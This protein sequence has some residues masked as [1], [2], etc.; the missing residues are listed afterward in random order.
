MVIV[1]QDFLLGAYMSVSPEPSSEKQQP[2]LIKGILAR[3]GQILFMF[4]VLGLILF[5]G[6]GD[7]H[8]RAAWI[9]LGI[10]ILSVL[11]NS[12]FMLR[13][14]PETVAERGTAKGW[15]DWDKLI[16]GLWAAAQYLF[17]P[18]I[19]ALDHRFGWTGEISIHWQ[20]SGALVYALSLALSGWAMI[21][22]AYFSTAA[23][24]Q[25]DRGQK[26]CKSGPYRYVRHPGYIGFGLQSVST[27][28]LLGSA[29]ALIPAVLAVAL[30]VTRTVFE[31]HM[32]RAELSG[33][34]EYTHEVRF[35]L[36]PGI[37]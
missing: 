2:N 18:L 15:R 14:S 28:L 37:W 34:E 19:A 23:R 6:S 33:Y 12:F 16:S 1:I 17:L 22:N 25:T 21:T 9:Y 5:I 3:G 30:M 35:Q 26:V 20:I 31:D 24:I 29:W 13:T 8:W 7:L 27:A 36:I 4:I 10:G 11:V 32:L